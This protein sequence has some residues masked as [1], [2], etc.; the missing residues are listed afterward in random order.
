MSTTNNICL[1]TNIGPHYRYPI[2]RTID[3]EF[4]CDFYLGDRTNTVIKTFNYRLLKGFK[5][6]VHNVFI[7]N[8]Y[9]QRSTVNLIFKPYKFYILDGEPYCISSW[10]ILILA[11]FSGKITISWTHGWYGREGKLKRIIKKI[12]YSLFTE[13]MVYNEYS[14]H[15][16]E[17]VG[18]PANRLHCI[19]NSLD[20]DKDKAI[21]S[22]L[23]NTSIFSE[24]FKNNFPTLIYCGRIQKSKKLYLI[25]DSLR[26]LKEKGHYLNVVFV[27]KDIENTERA[28]YAEPV[29]VQPQTWMVGPC[30]DDNKLGEL[31]YNAAV[32][33]SP[34]NVG[35]TA[36]HALSFGCPVITHNNF[37]YQMPD[38]EAIRPGI[39]GDFFKEDDVSDLSRV[40][41]DWC[42]KTELE[43]A[44]I[45]Q[46]AY[47]EI[48]SKWNIHYQINII[49]EI[50]NPH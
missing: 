50:V 12:F 2:F 6:T 49:K 1:I 29:G 40:I 27:G 7:H 36:I 14:I 15:L 20:S 3:E 24:H 8:V 26:L 38:F 25:L 9:W 17:K 22:K 35:L 11:K 23:R 10:L 31:F 45:R 44:K 47:Q 28:N 34:G 42:S 16:M 5:K 13:L 41:L 21:R 4:S 32:C 48:D 37:P 43:R 39:T 19:A 46:A 33:V 18:F 30:Y